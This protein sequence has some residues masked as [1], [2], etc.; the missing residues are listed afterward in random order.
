MRF[1][2]ANSGHTAIGSDKLARYVDPERDRALRSLADVDAAQRARREADRRR[3]TAV[4]CRNTNRPSLDGDRRC[5]CVYC[6]PEAHLLAMRAAQRGQPNPFVEH[7]CLCGRP[8]TEAGQR[9]TAHRHTEL[10]VLSGDH[11]ALQL[12]PDLMSS[13]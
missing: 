1:A 12:L 4:S 5:R 10:I 8:V 3:R 13:D 11:A 2:A 6:D 9:C 7:R